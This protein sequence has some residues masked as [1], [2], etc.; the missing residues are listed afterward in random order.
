M[1]DSDI[2]EISQTENPYCMIA[3]RVFQQTFRDIYCYFNHCGSQEE[4]KSGKE[5]IKWMVKMQGNFRILSAATPWSLPTF[6]QMCI[7]RINNIK[8]NARQRL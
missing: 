4:M 7:H 6:H 3:L 1:Y 2:D 8:N 5:S